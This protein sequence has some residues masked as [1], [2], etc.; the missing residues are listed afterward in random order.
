MVLYYYQ[1]WRHL[2][3]NINVV[4]GMYHECPLSHAEISKNNKIKYVQ[5]KFWI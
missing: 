2:L 4:T 3:Q 1:S 5:I